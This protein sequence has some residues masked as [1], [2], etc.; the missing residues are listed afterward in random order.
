MGN[1]R[2]WLLGLEPIFEGGWLHKGKRAR[3]WDVESELTAVALLG[4]VTIDLAHAKRAPAEIS[5]NAY[6]ILRDVEVLVPKGT[7]VELNGRANNDHL[8]NHATGEPDERPERV[9]RVQGHTLLGDVTARATDS[10][11]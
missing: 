7:F 1:R 5:V 9:V 10:H 11:E 6:A 3:T 8:N 4:D 2:R